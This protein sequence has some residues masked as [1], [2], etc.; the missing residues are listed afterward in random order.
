[1]YDLT[2]MSYLP[3]QDNNKNGLVGQYEFYASTDS[4]NWG[5]ATKTGTFADD[6][7]EKVVTF[8]GKTAR[9]I[10][11]RALSEVQ[12]KEYTAV[13]ELSVVGTPAP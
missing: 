10:R 3:R 12:G 11:F 2:E 7:S 8:P 9:Y 13:A 4:A 6:F 5:A 1:T